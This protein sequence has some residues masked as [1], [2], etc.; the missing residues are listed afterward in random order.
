MTAKTISV[1]LQKGGTG[2]TTTSQNLAAILGSKGYRVLLVD[3]DGQS[4]ATMASGIKDPDIT[5]SDVLA[6]ECGITDA[7]IPLALFYDIVPADIILSNFETVEDY[8]SDRLHLALDAVRDRYDYIVLDSP[9]ALGNLLKNVLFASD[10]VV[11]PL[12]PRP[13]SIHGIDDLRETL[14]AVQAATGRARVLGLLL[15]RYTARTV[16]CRNID[17]VAHDIAA[18]MDTN[19]FRTRIRESVTVGEAQSFGQ[20]LIEFAPKALVTQNYIDFTDEVLAKMGR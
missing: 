2:K 18:D 1:C 13:F 20:P 19:V 15:V 4:N 8:P 11:I 9:P 7:I 10:D 5:L 14:E 16:L 3:C 6:G 17:S 12:D